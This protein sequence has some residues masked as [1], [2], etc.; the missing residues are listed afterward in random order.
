MGVTVLA[1]ILGVV[2]LAGGCAVV[3]P[4]AQTQPPEQEWEALSDE[5]VIAEDLVLVV[6]ALKEEFGPENLL[7]TMLPVEEHASTA[8]DVA[9]LGYLDG[10]DVGGQEYSLYF[11]GVDREAMWKRLEPIMATAP[12][13]LAR[14]ELWPPGEDATPRVLSFDEE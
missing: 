6:F 9:G 12:Y 2:S 8:L 11:Y 14:V 3:S 10:N 7:D 13:P 5:A 4:S 1:L